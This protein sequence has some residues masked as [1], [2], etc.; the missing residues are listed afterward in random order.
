MREVDRV[1]MHDE[2]RGLDESAIPGN[3][4][5][6]YEERYNGPARRAH[7]SAPAGE[8]SFRHDYGL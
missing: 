3:R 4:E 2:A 6:R 1:A 7:E 8:R 5:T